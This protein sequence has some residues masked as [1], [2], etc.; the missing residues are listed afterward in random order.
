MALLNF[1]T[2]DINKILAEQY[3]TPI[4]DCVGNNYT[5]G[6]PLTMSANTEYLFVSNGATRN[7]KYLPSH[8]TNIWDTS[9]NKATFAQFVNI[10]EMVANVQFTFAP[11]NAQAGTLTLNV[12]VNE[13]VPILMKSYTVAYKGSAQKYTILSS[14]YAGSETGF[15][16]KNNGVFFKVSASGNGSLYDTSIE[17]FKT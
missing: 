2:A 6:L 14:F 13:T 8:I 10:P 1:T 11:S 4:Q 15:D 3:Q 17:I 16:V 12:Y 9:T 7:Q 5:S